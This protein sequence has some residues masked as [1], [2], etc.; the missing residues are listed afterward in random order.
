MTDMGLTLNLQDR[1]DGSTP[2]PT[3]VLHR[4]KHK[5]T[6]VYH[7]VRRSKASRGAEYW[8]RIR[9]STDTT[10]EEGFFSVN[11]LT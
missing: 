10:D 1:E 11:V 7:L 6:P 8:D 5:Q 3:E 2:G 4:F 9:I